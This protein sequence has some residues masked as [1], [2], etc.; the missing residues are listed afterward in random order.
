MINLRLPVV[1]WL[2]MINL[3]LPGHL[4]DNDQPKATNGHMV[5]NDQPKAPWS[6]G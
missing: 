2:I 5:D 1:T 6:L 4:V 3:R